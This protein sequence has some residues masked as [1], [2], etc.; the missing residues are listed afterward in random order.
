MPKILINE[1]IFSYTIKKKQGVSL[2][3]KLISPKSFQISCHR[4]VPEF[5]IIKFIK[6][7]S[8]WIIKNAVKIYPKKSILSLK[9]L[10]ILDKIYKIIILKTV[11]DSV[12]IS[13]N[14]QTIYI[15]SF[16][17]TEAHLRS[18]LETRLRRLALILIKSELRKLQIQHDFKFGNITV[19][20]QKSRFGSCSS[21]GNLN[22][23]WQIILFPEDK[24]RHILLHELNHLKIKNHK[25]EFW[26][27]LSVYDP[28]SKSNNLWLKKEGTKYFLIKP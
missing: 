2:G 14:E 9:E 26:Q 17:L 18:I 16:R 24:F 27:Q 7:H 25:A 19:R 12:I 4:F 22:F 11:R 1:K 8:D 28:N 20:N 6:D 23:N 5:L 21:V 13:E 3:L 15:N 10:I